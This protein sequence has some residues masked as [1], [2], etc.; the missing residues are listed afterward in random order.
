MNGSVPGARGARRRGLVATVLVLLLGVH[1]GAEE[2][3][4]RRPVRSPAAYVGPKLCMRCHF[5]HH[6]SWLETPHATA[7]DALRPGYCSAR[8][9]AAGLDPQR[10]Y[11]LDPTCLGCHATGYGLPGGYPEPPGETGWTPEQRER[12][13]RSAGVGCEACHGAGER[14]WRVMD[15][16]P[17]FRRADV[18]RA[19]AVVPVGDATCRT[20]HEKPCAT[21]G[22]DYRFD[23][24]RD[25]TDATVHERVPLRFP[26]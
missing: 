24:A 7:T 19:G 4:A 13:E 2:A 15:S 1:V 9:E 18:V 11:R 16:N 6:K 20:C 23:F 17:R 8:K 26:H 14:F 21:A 12:A 22:E 5:T 10:D 3:P 25:V